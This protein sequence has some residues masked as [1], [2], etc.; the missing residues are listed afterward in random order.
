MDD[1]VPFQK[2]TCISFEIINL[3]RPIIQDQLQ[4]WRPPQP[5]FFKLNTDGSWRGI[6]SAGGGGVIR[7]EDGGLVTGLSIS[8][9]ARTPLD[10]ELLALK[11]GLQ[12]LGITILKNLK[13][14]L[15]Q[16]SF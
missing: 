14:K 7:G 6:A 2:I 12:W 4:R 16:M 15:M 11:K 9:H 10:A 3:F 5:G 1:V 8:Y 13:S